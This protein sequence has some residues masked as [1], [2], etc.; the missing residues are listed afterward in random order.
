M[1][2]LILSLTDKV[3]AVQTCICGVQG[4][5]KIIN[6]LND[7]MVKHNIKTAIQKKRVCR[8]NKSR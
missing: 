5:K 1:N 6:S 3:V 8:K 7:M 2:A 4:F